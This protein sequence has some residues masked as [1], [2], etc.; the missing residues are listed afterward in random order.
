MGIELIPLTILETLSR[1]GFYGLFA[2]TFL[3]SLFLPMGSDL[4]FIGMLIAGMDPWLCLLI[5]TLGNWTGGLVIYGTSYYAPKARIEH[6]FHLRPGQLEKQKEKIDK[7]GSLLALIVWIPVI[8]D[9]SNIAL[10]F[11]RTRPRLT[12]LLMFMARMCRFL[13]WV[14]LYLAYRPELSEWARRL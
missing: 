13:L 6:W 1:L 14:I 4:L 7:Y 3:S 12:L 11:Y 5:A 9:I 8:G 2:G 10:G